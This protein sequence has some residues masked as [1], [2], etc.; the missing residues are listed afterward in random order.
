MPNWTSNQLRVTGNKEHLQA[1]LEAVKGPDS[2]FDF[3]KIIPMPK[4]I[5]NTGSGFH[6]FDDV[7]Y[8]T[9]YS[10]TSIEDWKERAKTERPLNDA[11]KAELKKIGYNN[12]YDWACH[13][14]GTKWNCSDVEIDEALE[15]GEVVIKFQTAWSA[16]LPILEAIRDKYDEL[17]FEL[18][19]RNE[20][21]PEYPHNAD[22]GE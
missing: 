11:E 21:D 3:D 1:F 12:W 4:V 9:W 18:R 10:D 14:W 16:P 15:Y 6:T 19:F 5:I 7:K 13:Y 22:G 20:D 8:E 17:V 2:G